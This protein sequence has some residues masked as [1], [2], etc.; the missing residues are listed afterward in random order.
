[1]EYLGYYKKVIMNILIFGAN[2]MLGTY[3][4]KYLTKTHINDTIINVSRNELD[5]S[6]VDENTLK[7]FILNNKPSWI[8]N[9]AGVIKPRIQHT[10]EISTIKI[11]SVF[12]RMLANI[13]ELNNIK[14]IHISTDG[15]FDG[16]LGMYTENDIPFVSDFYGQTKLLG[17]PLNCATMRVCPIGEELHNK[18]SL[19]EWIKSRKNLDANGF[20]NHL[21]NGLTSLEIAKII[22]KMID[23]NIYW[24]GIRHIHSPD[25]IS[26][27]TLLDYIN[28]IYN[29]NISINYI[30]DTNK[31]N[32]S[33]SSI[34][35]FPIEILPLK[36]QIR[37]LKNYL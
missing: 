25:T 26:K 37:E 19:I 10:G 22:S 24:L 31:V 14:C 12:P 18:R 17:E 3:I 20:T 32:R 11:N 1:M 7:S 23:Q 30:E 28:E 13:C 8:I 29:L 21:W 6:I 16:Q 34:H 33:L 4:S 35:I 15:V 2:G 27:A 9:C 5:I 36:D